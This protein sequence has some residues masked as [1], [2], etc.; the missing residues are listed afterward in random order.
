MAQ[1]G[2]YNPIAI[3]KEVISGN[4]MT[5]IFGRN[6]DVDAAEDIWAGGG[7]YTG[8][9]TGA[10]ETLSVFSSSLLD[11]AAGTGARTVLV[12]GLDASYNLQSEIITLNGIVA[13]VSVGT[14]TRM[15]RMTVLTAGT[16]TT[17]AGTITCR[18]TTTVADVFSVMPIGVS[19]T[20]VAGYT[21][22]LGKTGYIINYGACLLDTVSVRVE[23]AIKIRPFGGAIQIIRPFSMNGGNPVA[24]PIFGGIQL[25]PKT[26]VIMRALST[27]AVNAIITSNFDLLVVDD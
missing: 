18:H 23:C 13:V 21:I 17:N 16:G 1:D 19:V 15:F 22:P 5:Y 25:P 6:P 26:D 4:Y 14:Y 7:D 12:E 27:T 9:P 20:Q 10:A 11:T 2:L 24:I 8:F 3:A